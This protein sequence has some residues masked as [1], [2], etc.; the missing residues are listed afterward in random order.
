MDRLV[1]TSLSAMRGAM[2]RQTAIAN[3][4]ANANTTG[5]RAEMSSVRSLWL[6]GG[7]LESRAPASEEVLAADMRSG[8]TSTSPSPA[9]RCSR[10][11]A[12]KAT[13]PIRGAAI[14]SAPTA[15]C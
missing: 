4:L 7:A 11:R 12:R 15:D 1:H 3:N 2:A 14:S 9:M 10:C 8:A 5:F 13:K 6:Q